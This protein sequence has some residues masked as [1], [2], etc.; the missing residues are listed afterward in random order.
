[1]NGLSDDIAA[2]ASLAP[3]WRQAPIADYSVPDQAFEARWPTLAATMHRL[4]IAGERVLIHCRG[5]RGR[6]GLVAARL[7][8]DRGQNAPVALATVRL[9]QPGAVETAD[10]EASLIAYAANRF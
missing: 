1:M 9:A 3:D 6:S 2:L 4:L 5:G 8:I 7:L 10:Q